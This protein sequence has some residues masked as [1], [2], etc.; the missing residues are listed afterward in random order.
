MFFE[1]MVNQWLEGNAILTLNVSGP[2]ES[3]FPQGVYQP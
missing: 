2:R 1:E 3:K